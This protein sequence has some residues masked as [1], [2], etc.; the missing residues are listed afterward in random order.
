MEILILIK[1]GIL[2]TL[3]YAIVISFVKKG[4][5][6]NAA[7]MGVTIAKSG[8]LK[9]VKTT[10]GKVV[11]TIYSKDKQSFTGFALFTFWTFFW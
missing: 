8:S 6:R 4:Y 5:G 1:M 7:I 11:K 9:G 3:K 2:L 10:S